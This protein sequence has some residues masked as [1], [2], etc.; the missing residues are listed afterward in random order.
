MQ[1]EPLSLGDR[2]RF[3]NRGEHDLIGQGQAANQC[4][5]QHIAAQ[6]VR[7]RFKHHPQPRLRIP[8]PERPNRLLDGCRM[9]REVV[10]DRDP[11]DFGLHLQPPL[12]AAK[13][14]ERLR[15]RLFRNSIIRCQRRRRGRIP[16]VVF[17]AQRELELGPQFS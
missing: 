2:F 1:I 5:L 16:D 6:C 12:H 3:E 4:I 7:P 9:V 8:R 17:S 10:N 11:V 14:L 15:N 13:S